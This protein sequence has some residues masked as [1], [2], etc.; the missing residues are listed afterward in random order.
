MSGRKVGE[1]EAELQRLG[2]QLAGHTSRGTLVSEDM[3]DV[4]CTKEV[5]SSDTSSSK[6]AKS[7]TESAKETMEIAVSQRNNK[8][9]SMPRNVVSWFTCFLCLLKILSF[10]FTVISCLLVFITSMTCIWT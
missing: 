4:I 2:D 9:A 10:L 8:L 6:L 3:I 5:R 7:A 1:L